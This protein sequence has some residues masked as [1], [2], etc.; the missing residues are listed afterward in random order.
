MLYPMKI[1]ILF[2]NIKVH[3]VLL[4]CYGGL[5]VEA[6]CL[7]SPVIAQA[8][9]HETCGDKSMQN[10]TGVPIPIYGNHGGLFF[11]SPLT[12]DVIISSLKEVQINHLQVYP[13]PAID[14]VN[15]EWPFDEDA[16]IFI[17]SQ[18]G[19]LISKSQIKAQTISILDIQM[20][21]AGYYTIKAITKSNQT[22]ISKL[23]KQ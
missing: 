22:F 18:I 14:R 23:I 19:Q 5:E 6:Q 15:I 12:S 7:Y 3:L 16:D 1:A 13:N 9:Y 21:H 4:V 2:K 11:T 20:L 10:L 8:Y 17:Y